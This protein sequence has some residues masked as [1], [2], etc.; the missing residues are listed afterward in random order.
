MHRRR[1]EGKRFV[2][3]M[4]KRDIIRDI[5]EILP[6]VLKVHHV[7]EPMIQVEQRLLKHVY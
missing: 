1:T 3:I 6:H 7:S 2:T 4:G 5:S